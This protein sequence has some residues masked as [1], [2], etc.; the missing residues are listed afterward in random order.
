MR[1]EDQALERA[2]PGRPSGAAPAPRS[3]R[4]SPSTPVP[5][6]AEA[7][8]TSS[9]G[10]A[11]TL[12][13]SSMTTSGWADGRSILLMT[14]T[15]TRF[16]AQREVDVGERLGLDAL[17]GVDHQDRALAG[18]ERAADLVGEVDVAGRVDQVERR[19]V[20][21][22]RGRVLEAHR[23]G[24]D[25]DAVLALEVHRVEHLARHLPRVDRVGQLEQPVG[26]R[27]L[28]VID[29]GDDREVAQA[30]L[31]DRPIVGGQRVLGR[32]GTG[33]EGPDDAVPRC[34]TR[35]VAQPVNGPERSMNGPESSTGEWLRWGRE[36]GR[37]DDVPSV[38]SVGASPQLAGPAGSRSAPGGR[39]GQEARPRAYFAFS[40]W[41][42]V[43]AIRLSRRA[44]PKKL[45]CRNIRRGQRGA[46]LRLNRTRRSR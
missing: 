29:V 1:V 27:R 42:G 23:P 36:R 30:V 34:V 28:A 16:C 18:L 31:G 24:L 5:S 33:P 7:R 4:G 44:S 26:Q 37:R 11:R 46:E 6:L 2:R 17:G 19:S 10:M 22:S 20:W 14:G 25:R 32:C 38:M 41:V 13:S 3:P 12:S 15:I 45:A 9:R 39:P 21:P 40:H 43:P 8:S 35:R